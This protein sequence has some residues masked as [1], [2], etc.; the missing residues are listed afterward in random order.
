MAKGEGGNFFIF[1]HQAKKKKKNVPEH[2]K[3]GIPHVK[4]NVGAEHEFLSFTF[5]FFFG[6][7]RDGVSASK[8]WKTKV[9][10]SPPEWNEYIPKKNRHSES[11]PRTPGS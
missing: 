10:R 8:N 4:I 1:P 6:K 9:F 3:N 11:V 5:A 2:C 7:E